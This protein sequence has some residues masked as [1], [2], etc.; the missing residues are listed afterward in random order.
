MVQGWGSGRGLA[1][2]VLGMADRDG[3]PAPRGTLCAQDSPARESRSRQKGEEAESRGFPGEAEK[4]PEVQGAEMGG[5][6]LMTF[7]SGWITGGCSWHRGAAEQP[8][9][10]MTG[11]HHRC[12]QRAGLVSR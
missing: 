10:C 5:G 12:P 8:Q 1:P 2:P 6:V 4:Q 3:G 7:A 11:R 9:R